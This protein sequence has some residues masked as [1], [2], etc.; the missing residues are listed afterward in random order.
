MAWIMDR[1]P[2]G[3]EISQSRLKNMKSATIF[4]AICPLYRQWQFRYWTNYCRCW[5]NYCRC[6]TNYCQVPWQMSQ[7]D[8]SLGCLSVHELPPSVPWQMSHHDISLGCLSV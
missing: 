2:R 1:D 3:A 5:T 4:T 6:W 8:I 7:H